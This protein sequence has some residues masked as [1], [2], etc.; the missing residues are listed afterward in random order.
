[1]DK[2]RYLI[3]T[4]DERTWKFDRPVLFL[5]DNCCRYARKNIWSNMDAVV[6]KP[7]GVLAAQKNDD[8]AYIH[9][10]VNQLL[11]ELVE[12]LNKHHGTNHS[13]RYWSIVLGH[14]LLN[15]V[16]VAYNRYRTVQQALKIYS[17]NGTMV[18]DA[19]CYDL[20]TRDLSE[21]LGACNDSAWNNVF[22]S[23]IIYFLD[24]SNIECYAGSLGDEVR[25]SMK[26]TDFPSWKS[27]IGRASC[28]ERV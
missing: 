12:Q 15:Y 14:W 5:T 19:N 13:S 16:K 10:V 26:N 18:I 9:T 2:E 6:S 17:I 11:I 1:M 4:A 27:K 21:F 23:K 25:F 3:T 22:Y 24:G 7:Y 20:T 8:L 28:R